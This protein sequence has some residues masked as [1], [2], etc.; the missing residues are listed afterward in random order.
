MPNLSVPSLPDSL[1]REKVISSEHTAKIL[2]EKKYRDVLTFFARK[3]NTVAK[4]AEH[5]DVPVSNAYYY[6]KILKNLD[7]LCISSTQKRAGKPV[8]SYACN[9]DSYF[10]PT[11]VAP[12]S[13]LQDF[14]SSAEAPL[15]AL[16]KRSIEQHVYDR[17]GWGLRFFLDTNGNIHTAFTPLEGWKSWDWLEYDLLPE[18]VALY[19]VTVPLSLKREQ[20]KALQHEITQLFQ[21]YYIDALIS[22]ETAEP[23][24]VMK[25]ELAPMPRR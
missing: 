11:H 10:I 9:A 2:L 17:E 5:L 1:N 12:N 13:S 19:S 3:E 20:A 8:H 22:N 18:Q 21:R 7:I 15:N 25:L 4:L 23:S 24:H 14:L 16:L 6:V